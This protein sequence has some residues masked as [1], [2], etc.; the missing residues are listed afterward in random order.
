MATLLGFPVLADWG[1]PQLG[2][3]LV[4]GSPVKFTVA[5]EVAPIL[6]GFA[7]DF[8]REVEELIV[9]Q[10]GGFNPRNIAGT[11][12]KSRHSAG[13]AIDINWKKHQQGKHNTFTP[14]QVATIK[15]LIARYKV[16]RWGGTF[17]NPDDM[18]VEINA[19]RPVVLAA[20]KVLQTPA[21]TTAPKPPAAAAHAPGTRELRQGMRGGE[22]IGFLQ[23]WVGVKD[24]QNFG[25]ATKARVVRY[26]KVVGLTADGVCGSATWSRILGRTVHL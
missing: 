23:R 8:D 26:Q 4:P 5:K 3:Y 19:Q 15:R 17:T 24:D 9:G 22:D 25:S 14:A 21:K 18:H 11:N 13:L 7:R 2:T 6:I 20:V 12:V 16:L 1:V 10:C